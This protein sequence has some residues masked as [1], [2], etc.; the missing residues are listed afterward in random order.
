M[1]L[2]HTHQSCISV[3][4]FHAEHVLHSL[5]QMF[6]SSRVN[7]QQMHIVRL[8]HCEV[9][10]VLRSC[11]HCLESLHVYVGYSSHIAA[12]D[13]YTRI[14]STAFTTDLASHTLI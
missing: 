6:E 10:D 11:P 13:A 4:V 3:Q 1:P 8:M 12:L 9:Q 14:D 5:H 2:P 7:A